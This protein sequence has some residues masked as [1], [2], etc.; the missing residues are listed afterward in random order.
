MPSRLPYREGD[1]IPT[2]YRVEDSSG[3]GLAVGGGAVLGVAYA[4]SV[5]AAMGDT[6]GAGW[7]WV[8][9][10]GPFGSI[11]AQDVR[12]EVPSETTLENAPTEA[13]SSVDACSQKIVDTARRVTLLLIDGLVQVAGGSLLVVGLT[14]RQRE[15]VRDQPVMLTPRVSRGGYGVEVWGQF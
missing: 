1:P 13:T 15:L 8:P 4:A 9:V 2:G 11:L 14:T 5:V 12:C 6:R 3:S 7:L 10:V